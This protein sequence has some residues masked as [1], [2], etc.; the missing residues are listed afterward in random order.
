MAP[1]ASSPPVALVTGAGDRIGAVLARRLAQDGYAVVVHYRSSAEGA[2]AV[3]ADIKA[4]GGKAALVQ[5]DLANRRAARRRSS[6][7]PQSPSAR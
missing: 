3:V 7:R 6:P 1:K 2:K 5:A 4:L